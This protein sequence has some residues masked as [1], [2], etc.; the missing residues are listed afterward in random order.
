MAQALGAHN[1]RVAHVRELLT[2]KGRE[3]QRAFLL[4]GPT[5]LEEAAR[6]DAPLLALYVTEEMY[7][8]SAL[9]R[10]L[11]GRGVPVY[12]VNQSTAAKLS[13]VETPTG[14]V[15]V[16]AAR[17]TP[18]AEFFSADG[19]ILVLAELGD[20]GNAGT[21]LRSAD[22][23]GV[24]RVLFGSTSVE[25]F[26]PKVVRAT[27]GS[28]FHL[29][30]AVA[31]LGEVSPAAAG[32]EFVGLNADG[33]PIGRQTFGPRCALVVG[34]ERRGLGAWEA[35]CARTVSIPMRG[36]AESLNAAVAGSIALYEASRAPA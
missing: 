27:M 28:I 29:E 6:S 2:K 9:V 20:P 33:E 5:L 34:Q 30:I 1:T 19:L 26:N 8:A 16:C 18:L 14:I 12:V 13:D 36:Q 21:L 22:A 32:W 24:R 4:E 17:T 3:A 23:F 7:A 15:A 31:S 35:L 11:D 25:P 10:R